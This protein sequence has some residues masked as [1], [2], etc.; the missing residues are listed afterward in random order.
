MSEIAHYELNDGEIAKAAADGSVLPYLLQRDGKDFLCVME[1]GA[2]H[3]YEVNKLQLARL[4]AE[5]SAR[6]WSMEQGK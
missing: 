1:A 3:Q 6:L 5:C 4:A 2:Y